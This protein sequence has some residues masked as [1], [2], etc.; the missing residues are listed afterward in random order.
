MMEQEK[1]F[2]DKQQ[3]ETDFYSGLKKV[4]DKILLKAWAGESDLT[5][6]ELRRFRE[7]M[8]YKQGQ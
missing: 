3:L 4:I 2:L 6:D 8:R 1:E 5:E 7:V